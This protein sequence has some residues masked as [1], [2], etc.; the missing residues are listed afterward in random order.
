MTDFKGDKALY[1]IL[2]LALRWNL[3]SNV[4][5]LG[6]FTYNL[7]IINNFDILHNW[8]VVIS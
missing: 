1:L 7:K 5:T 3:H 6:A 4:I 2:H 8:K